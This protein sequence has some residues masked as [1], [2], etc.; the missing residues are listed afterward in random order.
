[1]PSST[2][3]ML[4]TARYYLALE[5]NPIPD[6]KREKAKQDAGVRKL[7]ASAYG[8]PFY[9]ERF[10]QVGLKPFDF[11][12]ADDLRKFPLLSKQEFQEWMH[13]VEGNP[14]Y[15]G[16]YTD[17]T[18]GSSGRPTTI[19]Y[20]QREKA[21]SVANWLRVLKKAGFDFVFGKTM[22]RH[23]KNDSTKEEGLIQK[24]GIMR[25]RFL[26]QY[27]DEG[28]VIEAINEYQPDLLYMNKTEFV[29]I[30]LYAQRHSISIWNPKLYLPVG[31]MVDPA[32]KN[33]LMNTFGNN[34]ADSFGTAETGA[35][36]LKVPGSNSHRVHADSFVVDLCHPEEA[37]R[38]FGTWGSD[39]KGLLVVTPLYKTDV[40]LINYVVGDYATAEYERGVRLISSIEGRSTD[41]IIHEDGSTTSFFMLDGVIAHCRGAAQIQFVQRGTS[42]LLVRVVPDTSISVDRIE[43]EQY[44]FAALQSSLRHPMRITIEWVDYLPAGANGKLQLIVNE[45]RNAQG[46]K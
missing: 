30:A 25:R 35:C 1:M 15:E 24:L 13:S 29:R 27:E 44:L 32:S 14:K 4:D 42:D 45:M 36:M 39:D 19:L 43:V 11:N 20:S 41:F 33:L 37:D 28:T 46:N 31:E 38:S 26:A 6:P 12:C 17:H 9:R 2:K 7:M 10:D 40:P 8:I 23:D 34:L 21:F 3:L 18:S 5:K 22:S 16:Y